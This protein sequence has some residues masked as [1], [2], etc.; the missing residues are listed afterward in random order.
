MTFGLLLFAAEALLGDW[1]GSKLQ[2]EL[3][4]DDDED[5]DDLMCSTKKSPT[6]LTNSQPTAQNYDNFNGKTAVLPAPLMRSFFVL[7]FLP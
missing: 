3:E 5:D 1:L 2:L 7:F 6:A 4:M